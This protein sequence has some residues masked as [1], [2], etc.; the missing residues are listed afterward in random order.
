MQ[1]ASDPKACNK[2]PRMPLTKEFVAHLPTCRPCSAVL[3][4]FDRDFEADAASVKRLREIEKTRGLVLVT[5][6][7]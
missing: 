3:A 4:M 7:S 6:R 1:N 5:S 2:F